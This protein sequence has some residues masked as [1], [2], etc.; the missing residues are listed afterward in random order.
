MSPSLCLFL[1]F[2]SAVFRSSLVALT[3]DGAAPCIP[4]VCH[5]YTCCRCT[6]ALLDLSRYGVITSE[7]QSI[8]SSGS[9][10]DPSYDLIADERMLAPDATIL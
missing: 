8:L 4:K 7:Y 6:M 3:V 9:L 1:L 5:A 10:C 2:P